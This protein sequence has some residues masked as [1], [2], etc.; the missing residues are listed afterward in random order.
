VPANTEGGQLR[1]RFPRC[2]GAEPALFKIGAAATLAAVPGDFNEVRGPA[3]QS[4]TAA[5]FSVTDVMAP[6]A[7]VSEEPRW[8]TGCATPSSPAPS[9]RQVIQI[10]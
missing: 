5:V 6:A 9:V 7:F 1:R 4:A 10:A 3:A 2:Q 8:P